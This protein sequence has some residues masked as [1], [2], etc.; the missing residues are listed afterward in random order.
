MLSPIAEVKEDTKKHIG[1]DRNKMEQL[2]KKIYAP[3]K[4]ATSDEVVNL[5]N[6]FWEEYEDQNKTGRYASC[7]IFGIQ[8][9]QIL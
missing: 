3:D 2:L 5:L 8:T 6:Q 9:M 7:P 4:E 1:D